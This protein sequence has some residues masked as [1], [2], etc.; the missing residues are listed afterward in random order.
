M[1]KYIILILIL[2]L[3]CKTQEKNMLFKQNISNDLI[4]ITPDIY[5]TTRDSLKVDIPLEFQLTNNSGRNYDYIETTFFIDKKYVSLGD[6]KNFDKKTKKI[7]EI[8]WE[9]SNGKEDNITSRL[10][11]L[12]ISLDDTKKI[13]K[14]YLINKDAEKFKDSAKL[15]PYSQFRKDFPEIIKKMEKIPDSIEITTSNKKE[16][17]FNSKRYKINW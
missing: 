15:V 4:Y 8:Y 17:Y 6:Y 2:F 3:S 16:K 10:E 7:K 12:Y 13:F 5:C 9:L 11:T 14:K 1:Y